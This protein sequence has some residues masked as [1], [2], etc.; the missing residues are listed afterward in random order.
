VNCL[1]CRGACCEEITI[2]APRPE[3]DYAHEWFTARAT[4]V[5][6]DSRVVSYAFATRC[7]RLTPDGLC[8]VQ[9]NKPR[10]CVDFIRGDAPC[11]GSISRRRTPEQAAKIAVRKEDP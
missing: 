9:T 4:P 1:K 5:V 11:R 6:V 3:N 10:A 7:P 8:S 2:E